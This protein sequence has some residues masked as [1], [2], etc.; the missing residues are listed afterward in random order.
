MQSSFRTIVKLCSFAV[1]VSRVFSPVRKMKH[2]WKGSTVSCCASRS[3]GRAVPPLINSRTNLNIPLACPKAF[4]LAGI[5]STLQARPA[6]GTEGFL[7]PTAPQDCMSSSQG[8]VSTFVRDSMLA[9]A[10]GGVSYSNSAEVAASD[11]TL[12]L[13]MFLHFF[14]WIFISFGRCSTACLVARSLLRAWQVR[15]T[16]TGP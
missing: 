2:L 16:N 13:S 6:Q 10:G 1:H 12:S 8:Q 7:E 15:S 4:S 14:L 11:I 5:F 9:W 3:R